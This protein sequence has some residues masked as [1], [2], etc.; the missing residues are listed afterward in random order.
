MI[1]RENGV[2]LRARLELLDA[3]Y[4]ATVNDPDAK[5]HLNDPTGRLRSAVN[6]I[7]SGLTRKLKLND[8]L[9]EKIYQCEPIFGK[10]I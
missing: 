3:I 1:D 7:T 5:T 4:T 6:Q 2:R 10:L 9:L 8:D